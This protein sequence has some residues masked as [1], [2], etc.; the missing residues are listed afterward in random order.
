MNV[1]CRDDAQWAALAGALG[2]PEWALDAHPW[3]TVPGRLAA[4]AAVDEAIASYTRER[5]AARV[6]EELQAAGAIAAPVLAPNEP[7]AAPQLHERGW[8]QIVDQPYLGER[9]MT[10]VL[11][12]Q[13]PDPIAWRRRCALLGEHNREVLAE[14]G[15]SA[16]EVADLEARDVVGDRYPDPE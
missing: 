6:A 7:P 16:G 2:H 1:V 8:F 13:Q 4:R 5:P 10:G 9:M 3:A 12:Q 15:Y 11:W 14:L